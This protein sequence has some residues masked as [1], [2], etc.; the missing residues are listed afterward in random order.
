VQLVVP[1][2]AI[3]DAKASV[4]LMELVSGTLKLVLITANVPRK[5]AESGAIWEEKI[6]VTIHARP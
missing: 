3:S 2:F 4:E 6:L 1:D 5:D